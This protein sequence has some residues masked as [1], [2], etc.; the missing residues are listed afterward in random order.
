MRKLFMAILVFIERFLP[1][2][3][4]KTSQGKSTQP[5]DTNYPLW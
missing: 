5:P 2:R 4:K 3:A 1:T